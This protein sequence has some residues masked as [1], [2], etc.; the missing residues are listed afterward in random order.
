MFTVNNTNNTQHTDISLGFDLENEQQQENMFEAERNAGRK[1]YNKNWERHTHT[2]SLLTKSKI[3]TNQSW[4][5]K[6]LINQ[7]AFAKRDTLDPRGFT[8]GGEGLS[9]GRYT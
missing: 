5:L 7:K 6:S 3:K 4:C 8:S 2:H 9:S 1:E